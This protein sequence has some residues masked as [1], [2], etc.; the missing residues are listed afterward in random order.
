[1]STSNLKVGQRID[2]FEVK[3]ITPLANLRATAIELVHS[4]TGAR[5]LHVYAADSENLFSVVFPTPPAD[6][7]GVPHILEHSVLGGSKRFP[8]KDP[9]FE[10][11]KCSMATFIN[12]MTASDHTMYPVASNVKQDFF[13][14]AEVYW[15]AVFHPTLTEMTFKREGH[16]FEFADK[17]NPASDLIVK[18]IVYNEMK[19]VFS[20]PNALVSRWSFNGLFP[21]NVYGKESGGD[22]DRIPD[23]TYEQFK[24]FHRTLY[25]PSNALIFLYGDIPT[26]EHLAFLK[27]RLASFAPGQAAP[28]LTKQPRWKA[29]VVRTEPYPVAKDDDTA[30]KT[31]ITINWMVADHPDTQ[32]EMAFE[33]LDQVLLG[34]EAAP[35]KKAI[36]DS[37]LGEDVTH[38]GFYGG[39]LHS[40]FHVG[41]KGSDP[42]RRP[43]FE[44]LVLD[45][46]AQVAATGIT[47]DR[48][49]AAFQQL[50]YHYLEVTSSFPL[51]LM[52]RTTSKWLYAEDPLTMLRAD[53]HLAALRQRYSADP[54]LFSRLIQEKL[55]NNP[56]RLT[57][58]F[59]PDTALGEKRDAE[60]AAKMKQEKAKL[61]PG[62]QQ[63]I[64][65]ETAEL[66]RLQNTPNSPEALATLPQ[67][68]VRDLPPKPKHIPTT[69]EKLEGGVELL[70]NDVLA[71]GVNYLAVDFDL[72]GLSEEQFALLPLYGDCIRKMGTEKMDFV[73]MAERVAAHTGGIGFSAWATP[74]VPDPGRSVRRGRFT[75]KFLDEKAAEALAVLEDFLFQLNPADTNRLRD[76]L[77]QSRA[78]HRSSVA[79][80]GLGIANAHA[81]RGI[82]RETYLNEIM[83]GLPQ[84]RLILSLAEQFDARRDGII[85]QLLAVRSLLLNRK[86]M[87]AS[88]TGTA[89]VY[90]T[91]RRTLE[92]WSARMTDADMG[93]TT[94]PLPTWLT[95]PRE[96][97]AGPM[98]VAYC[99]QIMPA[100]HVSDP[101]SPLITVGNLLLS[102]EYVLDEVRFKGTAYG[103]GCSYDRYNGTAGFYSY[104]D[105]WITRT[106][107]VYAGALDWLRRT[108]WSQAD[109]DRAIIGTSKEG[110]RP[111]RPADATGAALWRHQTGETPQR[112]EKRHASILAAKAADVKEAMIGLLEKNFSR[113]AVCVVSSQ[114]KLDA[115]NRELGEGRLE[116][117]EILKIAD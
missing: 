62:Q 97:L 70:R 65:K 21:D 67:L 111:I 85:H 28:A 83:G 16:H 42:D 13:N 82:G 33:V 9:F 22:P 98:Q 29:P 18:G 5:L 74:Y 61:S 14:L 6:D 113:A 44:K 103:G 34:N 79:E 112:R 12:A 20:S 26:Q 86:R 109:V 30:A 75:M 115:A 55:L 8:V 23:L 90:D 53:E 47:K 110:E 92:R 41:I 64:L 77:L 116:V 32:E 68:R 49:D 89:G 35:L 19:G 3:R 63:Q 96:G 84:T 91:V 106:L 15:D 104:R 37:K 58:S 54:Q 27:D 48:V 102:M 107:N 69:V 4:K 99:S 51:N 56:H 40:S 45:T 88:F 43:A 31:Y 60:F 95:P 38:A 72:A 78:H 36:I 39:Y 66:E 52:F 25:H 46:L 114:E 57:I 50:S 17:E 2:G 81:A 94:L 59:I 100:P 1:M 11:V 117:E 10:M 24:T 76:V 73:R 105:P 80:R 87:T 101:L 7:T 93:E 71:N 108:P